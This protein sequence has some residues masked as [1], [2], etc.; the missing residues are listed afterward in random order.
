MTRDAFLQELRIAMQGRIPQAQVNEHLRYYEN[1]IIEESRKGRTEEEVLRFLGDPRL[2]AKTLSDASGGAARA[3]R[4]GEETEEPEG[5]R[6]F[7]F[8]KLP[9]RVR[10]LLTAFF[11]FACVALT[12]RI[13]ILILPVLSAAAM[14]AGLLWAVY[15]IFFINHK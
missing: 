11:A 7:S 12:V 13:G 1:Y 15:R 6:R 9:G 8:F 3:K 4:Y 5:K 14:I 2:I 10:T